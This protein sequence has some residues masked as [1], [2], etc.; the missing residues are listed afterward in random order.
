[1]AST[2]RCVEIIRSSRVFLPIAYFLRDAKSSHLCWTSHELVGYHSENCTCAG[3]VFLLNS[4]ELLIYSLSYLF[5][6]VIAKFLSPNLGSVHR[7]PCV[8]Q[9]TFSLHLISLAGFV[10]RQKSILWASRH[11]RV[12]SW[13]VHWPE[14][15]PSK[16]VKVS[17]IHPRETVTFFMEGGGYRFFFSKE[18]ISWISL[19]DAKTDSQHFC[20]LKAPSLEPCFCTF[21]CRSSLHCNVLLYTRVAEQEG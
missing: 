11:Y 10:Y 21:V 3:F 17:G 16:N 15:G 20:G 7:Q 18:K 6:Y 8:S 5:L 9:A 2:T 1:M 12:D 4:A 19:P 14:G 13:R